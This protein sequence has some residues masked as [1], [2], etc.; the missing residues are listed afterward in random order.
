MI[1]L[2]LRPTV[3][4]G[5]KFDNDFAVIW[6]SEQFGANRVGRIRLSSS[7]AWQREDTWDWHIN[8][9]LPIPPWG[10]GNARSLELAQAAFRRAFERFHHDTSDRQWGD[11]FAMQRA[12]SERPNKLG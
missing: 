6:T 8:P 5:H 7:S 12:S 2:A 1:E 11:A 10:N 9:P 3:I 4:N